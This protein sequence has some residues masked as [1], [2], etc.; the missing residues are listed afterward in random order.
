MK[1]EAQGA[2]IKSERFFPLPFLPLHPEGK[3]LLGGC[4]ACVSLCGFAGPGERA[5]GASAPS[6]L[7]LPRTGLGRGVRL[8]S[9]VTL[10]TPFGGVDPAALFQDLL[11]LG[12]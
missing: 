9:A 12:M 1:L 8:C 10:Y 4:V 6:V 11:P 5:V 7:D 3:C 2:E